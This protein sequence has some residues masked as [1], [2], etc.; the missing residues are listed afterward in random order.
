VAL[1]LHSVALVRNGTMIVMSCF[2]I[3][4]GACLEEPAELTVSLAE[5]PRLRMVYTVEDRDVRVWIEYARND[6]GACAVLGPDFEG[7][8]GGTPM[9]VVD[10]GGAIEGDL[11]GDC[12]APSLRLQNPPAVSPASLAVI[13]RS[14][15]LSCALGDA[16]LPRSIELVPEGP[17]ELLPGQEVTVRWSPASDLA[18][19]PKV[20]I[21]GESAR[22]LTIQGD[23]VTFKM[24]DSSIGFGRQLHFSSTPPL[25]C[26]GALRIGSS[27]G[28]THSFSY[29]SGS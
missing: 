23:L 5:L 26:Q 27:T 24:P 12:D 19:E 21:E 20:W 25:A 14:R 18:R 22:P 28:V 4:S 13:D 15:V 1:A 7:R 3:T 10:R 16:L 6:L 2:G 8:V 11:L 9:E 29:R 17:W